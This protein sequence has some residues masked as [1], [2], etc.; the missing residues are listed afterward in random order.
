MLEEDLGMLR[1]CAVAGVRV[2]DQL[3]IWQVFGEEKGVYG[4]DDDV[5][6]S[7]NDQR[8]LSNFSQH[9]EPVL[10][11]N[12][13]PFTN[14]FELRHSSLPGDRLIMTR[15]APLQPFEIGVS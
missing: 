11:R 5:L 4:R 3:G 2:D 10:C 15:R 14:G 6:V 8:R 9:R 13:P 12:C 7:V 1:L